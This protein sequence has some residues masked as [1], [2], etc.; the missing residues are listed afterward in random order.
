MWWAFAIF[1]ST[2]PI[3]F[4]V[5]NKQ[6]EKEDLIFIENLILSEDA[7]SG[8]SGGKSSS[9]FIRFKFT[10]SK[11][12]FKISDHEYKCVNKKDILADFKKGDTVAISI[13]RSDK[14]VFYESNWFY[15]Y[16]MIY[17][18]VKKGKNYLSLDCRNK[19]SNKSANAGIKASISAA[20]LSL[21]FALF[22]FKPKTKYQALGQFPIDPILVVIIVW[23]VISLALR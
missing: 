12:G 9:S 21:L 20:I 18:L 15:K 23:L 2:I 8:W 3:F 22:V 16:S 14:A 13:K 19:V 1:L 5:G 6:L 7:G 11:R 10:N 4:F 17:G